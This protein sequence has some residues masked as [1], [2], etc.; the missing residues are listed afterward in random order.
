[1]RSN[2]H[3]HIHGNMWLR[4]H[5]LGSSFHSIRAQSAMEYLMTYGWA[6]LVIAIV[7]GVL[8]YLG[9]FNSANFAP[10]A[11]P[12]SC[13]VARPD[14]AGT[15][16]D[17][18]L[19]GICNNE[20]PEYVAQFNGQ[21]SYISLGNS[22]ALSPEAGISGQMTLCIWYN[23]LS[24]TSYH[25][26]LIKGSSPPSSGNIWEYTIGQASSQIYI[27]WT[28]AGVNI[29]E[30]V[31]STPPTN[32]WNFACFTYN[33]PLS[34]SYVYI[35]GIKSTATFTSGTPAMAGTGNLILGAGESGYSNVQLANF[36]IYNTALSQNDINVLYQE[37]IGGAPVRLQNLVG[38]WPLNGNAQDYSGNLN[39]G[40]PSNIAYTSTWTSGYTAP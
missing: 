13:Q 17:I 24:T 1:M 32:Q 26:F 15:S 25:G 3:T 35:D 20:L 37:G 8:Y 39:N 7:L 9:V 36:Q 23:V 12:G 40:V 2:T 10:R 16:T 27:V 29:A 34:Q 18:G 30:Y 33:Y 5:T 6:I 38:W 31:A 22:D 19:S 11:Q 14:G 21:N 4:G 28:P